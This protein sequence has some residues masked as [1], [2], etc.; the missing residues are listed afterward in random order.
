MFGQGGLLLADKKTKARSRI[1]DISA[2]KASNAEF[3]SQSGGSLWCSSILGQVCVDILSFLLHSAPLEHLPPSLPHLPPSLTSLPPSLTPLVLPP[4]PSSVL[5]PP[6]TYSSPSL[7]P[8]PTSLLKPPPAADLA[9]QRQLR[10]YATRDQR[11]VPNRPASRVRPVPD[12]R[13]RAHRTQVCRDERL[14]RS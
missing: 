13:R 14:E 8:L 2:M 1:M 11:Q 12:V 4:S 10:V 6:L 7:L 5:C 9:R 3:W